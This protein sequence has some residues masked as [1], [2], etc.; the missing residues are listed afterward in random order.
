MFSNIEKSRLLPIA[1]PT[2]FAP[3]VE[4]R[5]SSETSIHGQRSPLMSGMEYIYIG[6]VLKIV[7]HALH[8]GN[9]MQ[10]CQKIF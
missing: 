5:M 4:L 3:G 2:I 9:I 10:K 8:N 7:F 1:V 6:I